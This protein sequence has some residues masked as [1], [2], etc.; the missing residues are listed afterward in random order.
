MLNESNKKIFFFPSL[1]LFFFSKVANVRIAFYFTWFDFAVNFVPIF[2]NSFFFSSTTAF[3]VWERVFDFILYLVQRTKSHHEITE[4]YKHKD[5]PLNKNYTLTQGILFIFFILLPFGSLFL[6][7][8]MKSA[9]YAL[10]NTL[11]VCIHTHKHQIRI[12]AYTTTGKSLN[13]REKKNQIWK[14]YVWKIYHCFRSQLRIYTSMS[15]GQLKSTLKSQLSLF[16]CVCACYFWLYWT[17]KNKNCFF[18]PIFI[19]KIH[20]M[21][22]QLHESKFQ[23]YMKYRLHIEL[24]SMNRN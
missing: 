9:T 6:T 19:I 18:F 12:L 2:E 14:R 15:I 17:Q 21:N 1:L 23:F 24:N 22:F 13:G 3:C 10:T 7:I 20:L 5:T 8:T 11:Q 4:S 16:V